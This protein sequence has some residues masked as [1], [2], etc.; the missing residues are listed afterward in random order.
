[1]T[2]PVPTEPT[3]STDHGSTPADSAPP[4]LSPTAQRLADVAIADLLTR[5]DASADPAD[6]AVV[7]VEEVNWRNGSLGCPAKGMQYTQVIT[8]GTRIV[9]THDGVSY[10]YHAGSGRDPF[11]CATPEAPLAD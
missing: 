3:G 1:M 4:T 9:L 8:P 5:L 6:I 7:S 2:E 10:E 11:Y